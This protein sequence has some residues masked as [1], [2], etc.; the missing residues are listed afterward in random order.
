[1]SLK[2]F[3]GKVVTSVFE[4]QGTTVVAPPNASHQTKNEIDAVVAREK[5][6]RAGNGS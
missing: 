4:N 3:I 5:A 6:L 1:M 2:S